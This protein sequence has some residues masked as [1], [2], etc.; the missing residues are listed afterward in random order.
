VFLAVAWPA[1]NLEGGVVVDLSSLNEIRI[2]PAR[3]TVSL[4]PGNRW[5]RVYQ[6]LA[7]Y[8]LAISG[9]IWG[10][11]GV[12]GLLTGGMATKDDLV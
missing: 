6:Q 4:G 1:N 7:P 10:N 5:N 12:G 2:D 8:G 9:G 11:V 3:N